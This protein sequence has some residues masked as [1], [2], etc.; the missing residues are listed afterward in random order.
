MP[1]AGAEAAAPLAPELLPPKAPAA[2]ADDAGAKADVLPLADVLAGRNFAHMSDCMRTQQ[3][4]KQAQGL[5]QDCGL[6]TVAS[7]LAAA[8]R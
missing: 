1:K 8:T 3:G 6:K 4:G 7:S 5:V 2:V